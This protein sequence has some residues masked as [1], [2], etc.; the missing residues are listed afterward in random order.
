MGLNKTLFSHRCHVEHADGTCRLW[1]RICVVASLWRRLFALSPLALWLARRI[2]NLRQRVHQV[3]VNG[4][5]SEM[6]V[7]HA[8]V[9][10]SNGPIQSGVSTCPL[11]RC[12][13]SGDRSQSRR[14]TGERCSSCEPVIRYEVATAGMELVVDRSS[15][16]PQT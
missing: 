1:H 12:C 6:R 10:E 5:V 16:Q 15:H 11:L 3:C 7:L 14:S 9:F 8:N 13:R 2:I 4:F